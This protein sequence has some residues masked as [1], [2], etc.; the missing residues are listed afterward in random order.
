[1][2]SSLS[3]AAVKPASE[4]GMVTGLR[5]EIGARLHRADH[6]ARASTSRPAPTGKSGSSFRGND[7]PPCLLP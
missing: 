3:I 4:T 6:K 2:A 7:E 1:M 5:V